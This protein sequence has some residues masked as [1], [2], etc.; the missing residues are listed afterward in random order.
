[1]VK[2]CVKTKIKNQ[3]AIA[4]TYRGVYSLRDPKAHI[5][6]FHKFMV[7]KIYCYPIFLDE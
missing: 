3:T 7:N 2:A 5:L 4:C 1:M 6:S